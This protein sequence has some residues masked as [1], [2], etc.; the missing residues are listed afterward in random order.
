MLHRLGVNWCQLVQAAMV[1]LGLSKTNFSGLA[2]DIVTRREEIKIY[3][4][5]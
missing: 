1:G 3:N 4:I 2:L 5:P